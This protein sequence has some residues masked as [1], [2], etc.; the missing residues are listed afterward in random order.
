MRLLATLCSTFVIP[1]FGITMRHDDLGIGKGLQDVQ[2]VQANGKVQDG[3]YISIQVDKIDGRGNVAPKMDVGG[4]LLERLRSKALER[5]KLA[6]IFDGFTIVVFLLH[7]WD[8]TS[9]LLV[10]VDAVVQDGMMSKQVDGQAKAPRGRRSGTGSNHQGAIGNA[11]TRRRRKRLA[12]FRLP[13]VVV[14]SISNSR[15][16]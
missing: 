5:G 3:I 11:A 15:L 12:Q 10:Q 16:F 2:C 1:L 14:N 9:T 4:C 13:L 7:F 8:D 6:P